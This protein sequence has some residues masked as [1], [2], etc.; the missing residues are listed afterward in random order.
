MR[1]FRIQKEESTQWSPFIN[2]AQRQLDSA[3]ASADQIPKDNVVSVRCAQ[4]RYD[5]HTSFQQNHPG[6]DT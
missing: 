6:T 3:Q 1:A 4:R 5:L 2:G